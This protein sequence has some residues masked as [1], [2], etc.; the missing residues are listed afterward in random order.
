[1]HNA[2]VGTPVTITVAALS[3]HHLLQ[4]VKELSAVEHH[5][6]AVVSDHLREIERRRLYLTLGCSSMF[7]YAVRELGYSTG[8][9]WRRLKAMRLCAEVEGARVRLQEGTLT[10]DAAAQL[11]HASSGSG[12]SS[13]RTLRR[14]GARRRPPGLRRFP[15]QLRRRR[16]QHGRTAARQCRRPRCLRA[17]QLRRQR[18]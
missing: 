14:R 11:Q 2:P 13:R 1:M 16:T 10:L 8:A 18:T 15:A 4:R 17:P 6:E 12:A 7:D 3:D 5:I 9:A